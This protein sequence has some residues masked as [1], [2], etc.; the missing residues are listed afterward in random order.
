MVLFDLYF[1]MFGSIAFFT[2]GGFFFHLN[3]AEQSGKAPADPHKVCNAGSNPASA[4]LPPWEFN[5]YIKFK[6]HTAKF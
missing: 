4:S 2:V 5:I 3:S 6:T 1:L